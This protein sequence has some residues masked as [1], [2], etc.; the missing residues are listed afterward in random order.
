MKTIIRQNLWLDRNMFEFGWGN[1]YVLIPKNHHLHGKHYTEINVN[2]HGGLTY[3][4]LIDEDMID[5]FK[6]L[7]TEDDID[8]WC[9][10]FDTAHLG[11]NLINCSKE[12]VIR[13]TNKLKEQLMS[14]EI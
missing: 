7:F 2:V 11:D 9:V 5:S 12:Y 8:S 4:D 10:G 3:S 6:D 1:G 13:E 14:Y